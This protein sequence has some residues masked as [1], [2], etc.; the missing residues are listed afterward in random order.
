[1]ISALLIAVSP[2]GVMGTEPKDP[3]VISVQTTEGEIVLK[4]LLD[5]CAPL[6]EAKPSVFVIPNV[7]GTLL[8]IQGKEYEVRVASFE[9][10]KHQ[11]SSEI[12][13]REYMTKKELLK[14]KSRVSTRQEIPFESFSS[15]HAY[16][17]KA[18]DDGVLYT[19][20]LRNVDGIPH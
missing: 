15:P 18:E 2:S 3:K 12:T 17:P 6:A 8:T 1:M 16:A 5:V 11:L 19:I 7:I 9:D 10:T 20:V 4:D 13:L 14:S